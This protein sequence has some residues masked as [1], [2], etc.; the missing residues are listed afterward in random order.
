MPAIAK[1]SI[2]CPVSGRCADSD[3]GDVVYEEHYRCKYGQAQPAVGDHPVDLIGSRKPTLIF[4][5]VAAFDYLGDIYVALIGDDAF[6]VIVQLLLGSFDVAVNV[7]ENILGDVQLL[8]HLV[9]ALEYLYGVPALL[10]KGHV[11]YGG[12]LDVSDS[13]LNGAGESMH[14]D[15]F[16]A[17]GGFDRGLCGFHDAIALQGGY[18][19]YP[20]AQLFGKLGGI[21]LIAILAHNVHHIDGNDYRNA[22]LGKLSGEVK[23]ALQVGSV[24]YVQ[25]GVGALVDKIIS[26]D[27]FLQGIGGKR[28]DAG[29]VH[30][31]HILMLPKAAFLLFYGNAWPVA[32]KLVGTGQSVEQRG[33]AAVRVAG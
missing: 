12:L 33:F 7:I 13:V 32:D 30:Y 5:L 2:V 10:L 14:G 1:Q 27:Y 18:L 11:M 9:V 3:H 16:C 19:Y 26:G 31:D 29:Q 4:F 15:G 22:Q 25:Y 24:D 21:Y 8:K 17:M 28:I 20:A 6:S 23:V